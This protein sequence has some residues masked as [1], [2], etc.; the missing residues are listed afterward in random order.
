MSHRNPIRATGAQRDTTADLYF[1]AEVGGAS[2]CFPP[3][4]LKRYLPNA[5][6]DV[7]LDHATKGPHVGSQAHSN[8]RPGLALCAKAPSGKSWCCQVVQKKQVFFGC[9][10]SVELVRVWAHL[11]SLKTS[12]TSYDT[13]ERR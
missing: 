5:S 10:S 11:E 4:R 7:R 1:T 9:F 12:K 3:P 13:R 8:R 6:R 2:V